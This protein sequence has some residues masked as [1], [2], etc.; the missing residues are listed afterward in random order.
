MSKA[1]GIKLIANNKKAF[2]DFFIEETFEAGISLA[3]T[4]VK[5]SAVETW[6]L[7]YKQI[8]REYPATLSCS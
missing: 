6:R 3:G 4:E 2:H 5:S 1:E 8:V 7:R